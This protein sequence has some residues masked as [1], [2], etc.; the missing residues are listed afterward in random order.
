VLQ[1]G[2]NMEDGG[3]GE[4]FSENK[5]E[6]LNVSLLKEKNIIANP[7]FNWVEDCAETID[8]LKSAESC[9]CPIFKQLDLPVLPKGNKESKFIF[10]SDAPDASEGEEGEKFLSETG[11][12]CF[13][14]EMLDILNL[15]REE[16]Y[17]T[18]YVFCRGIGRNVDNKVAFNCARL[19]KK[20]FRELINMEYIFTLGTRPLQFITGIF[21]LSVG[22]NVGKYLVA[23]IF[24]KVVKIIP[25]NS[26]AYLIENDVVREKNLEVLRK[27]AS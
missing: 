13:F 24:D 23:K 22:N 11:V 9:L 6:G 19:H 2:D 21:G 18:S 10:I 25:L 14:E 17:I 16:I 7:L 8:N 12:G 27:L 4:I 15:K 5:T 3:F 1:E 20:E 26:P